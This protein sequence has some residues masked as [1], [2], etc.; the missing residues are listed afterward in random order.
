[1]VFVLFYMLSFIQ[2][3]LINLRCKSD[4]FHQKEIWCEIKIFKR[5]ESYNCT[6]AIF[7]R[8]LLFSLKH[9]CALEGEERSLS[10]NNTTEKFLSVFHRFC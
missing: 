8:L 1:M 6:E 9:A 5:R 2:Q 4:N 3:L 7:C 10:G